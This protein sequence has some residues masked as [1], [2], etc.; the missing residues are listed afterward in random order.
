[1]RDVAALAGVGLKTV[2]RVINNEPNVSE[3]TVARVRTA[4]EQ[5]RFRPDVYAGNLK[6]SNRQTHSLGLIVGSVAN[7]FSGQLH[8][9]VEDVAA[10]RNTVV[11]AGSLDDN[12]NNEVRL[13]TELVRRRVDGIIMTTIA[14]SQGYLLHEQDLGI[15]LVFVD[16]KPSGVDADAVVC[17]NA[18]GAHAAVAHLVSHG[19]ERIGYLGDSLDLWTA[20]ERKRGFLEGLGNAGI[21]TSTSIAVDG[22]TDEAQA[23]DAVLALLDSGTPP[24][25]LF[26][27][28]N[29]VTIGA[30][31]ALRERGLHRSI[32]IVGFDD[33]PLGDLIEPGVT[34]L[35]QDPY[36]IG[37]LAAE[38]MFA[39]LD[40]AEEEPA[41][42][43]VPVKLIVRGS[44][45]IRPQA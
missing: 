27:S 35:A 39:R 38:R 7:P 26:T 6:R 15:H 1:M 9:A 3:A 40:G 20:R 8:R 16:R 21:P 4:A 33:V 28:Q 10:Q 29:L 12:A 13:V 31:R 14:P 17:D 30:L 18:E 42:H 36:R 37:E 5:L 34:V 41:T 22:L 11:M 44:G 32:A 19:H 45:E 24:T 25:A 2:S 23:R 43:V